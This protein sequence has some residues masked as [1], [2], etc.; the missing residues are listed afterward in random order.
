MRHECSIDRGLRHIQQDVSDIK[1]ELRATNQRIDALS[2]E[3][4]KRFEKSDART[5][6]LD[7]KVNSSL[8]KIES[9]KAWVLGLHAA[10]LTAA[11]LFAMAKGFKWF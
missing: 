4:D 1:I 6:K 9:W 2:E 11:L 8:V 7:D 10:A 5:D 3:M